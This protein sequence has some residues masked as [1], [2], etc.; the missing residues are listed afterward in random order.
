MNGYTRSLS[1]S[2]H[3]SI[4]L[5]S[6]PSFSL[7][8]VYIYLNFIVYYD[9]QIIIGCDWLHEISIHVRGVK[10]QN[11]IPN[12]RLQRIAMLE[13]N[14][15]LEN[16][17]QLISRDEK[18][19]NEDDNDDDNDDQDDQDQEQ[20][21]LEQ[22]KRRHLALDILIWI[23]GIRLKRYRSPKSERIK[24]QINRQTASNCSDLLAQQFECIRLAESHLEN[25]LRHCILRGDRSLA[26]KCLQLIIL[27]TE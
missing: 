25:M 21:C 16:L 24:H 17:F 7:Y 4:L 11:H 22:E 2:F 15:L 23:Y 26:H 20:N 14:Q 10:P 9:S 13:S 6:S 18:E 19:D 3:I 27:I 1:L 12:E 5:S 8:N